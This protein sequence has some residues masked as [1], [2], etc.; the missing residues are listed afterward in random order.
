MI[1]ELIIV[2]TIQHCLKDNII[3]HVQK[4]TL[5]SGLPVLEGYPLQRVT[6]SREEQWLEYIR[7]SDS[8]SDVV[9][10]IPLQAIKN[11]LEKDFLKDVEH[12]YGFKIGENQEHSSAT[13]PMD[14]YSKTG[15]GAPNKNMQDNKYSSINT[16]PYTIDIDVEILNLQ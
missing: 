1:C 5:S 4:F 3:W 16:L 9:D 2:G 12:F 8:Q 11:K 6:L 14:V 13:D 15:D 7:L 10:V